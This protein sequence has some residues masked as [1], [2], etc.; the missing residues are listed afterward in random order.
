MTQLRD[1]RSRNGRSGGFLFSPASSYPTPTAYVIDDVGTILHSWSHTAHQPRRED[2]PPSYLRGWN[3]VEVDAI[4]NLF[5][6]VPLRSLLKLTPESEL[7]WSCDVAAHHDVA[8]DHD[9][10]LLVLSEAPRRVVANGRDHVVLDNLV[11]LIGPDGTVS[12]EFSTYDILRTDRGLRQLIDDSIVRRREE[13]R[14]RGW[15]TH[16]DDVPL[17]VVHETQTILRTASHHG[18][19]RRALQRL[20]D[21]PG[22]PCDVL[23]TNT[24]ELL[25]AHPSGMWNRGDVL[26]CMRELNTIAVVDLARAEV[27]WW[28][29]PGELSGPHQPVGLPDGRVLVFDNGVEAGRTRLVAVD[30]S[31]SEVVWSWSASP[32]QSFFC[33]LAGGCERLANGNLLVTNSTAGGAFELTME[34]EILW[35]LNLPADFYGAER[36]RVSI[37]RMSRVESDVVARF[38]VKTRPRGRRLRAA[39]RLSGS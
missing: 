10:S 7:E 13:F 2:D 8:I 38:K 4:G 5:A 16:D 19:R 25:G 23:H 37:Y 28:W 26:L 35:Q 9:G 6:I 29:G 14:R 17:A 31:T 34:G 11:T 3:H 33:P 21:L 32:P 36:G 24:L 39:A 30:P 18:E 27:R 22:S 20:R 15:P 12:S 1:R